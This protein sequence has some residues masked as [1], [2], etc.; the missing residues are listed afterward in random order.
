MIKNGD[1]NYFIKIWQ[2][3]LAKSLKIIIK[4]KFSNFIS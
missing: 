4:A 2:R 1:K 3:S